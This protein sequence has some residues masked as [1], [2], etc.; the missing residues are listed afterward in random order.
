MRIYAVSLTDGRDLRIKATRYE[1]DDD[2]FVFLS[3]HGVVIDTVQR[4]IVVNIEEIGPTAANVEQNALRPSSTAA[5]K[6]QDSNTNTDFETQRVKDQRTLSQK[7]LDFRR[8]CWMRKL[9]AHNWHECKWLHVSYHEDSADTRS[10]SFMRKFAKLF[11]SRVNGA[12][13][14]VLIAI[15]LSDGVTSDNGVFYRTAW[16]IVTWPVAQ[17]AQYVTEGLETVMER[18]K[19]YFTSQY[20]CDSASA[21]LDD[22]F[23]TGSVEV[24][25]RNLRRARG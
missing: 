1:Q 23:W 20:V 6:E 18:T 8:R 12:P 14:P 7:I 17:G 13:V 9:S 10:I 2:C 16:V 11:A 5:T 21:A 15:Q 25:C 3:E 22:L 4:T 19:F 24:W